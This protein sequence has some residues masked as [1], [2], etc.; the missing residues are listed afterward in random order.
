[1]GK[2]QS[3]LEGLCGHALSYGAESIEVLRESDGRWWV[4][5]NQ[6]GERLSIF[7]CAASSSDWTELRENLE[8][9]LKKPVRTVF[10]G[11]V[12]LLKATIPGDDAFRVSTEMAPKIDP[13]APPK[14]TSRQGQYLAYIHS[15]TKVHRYPP[16]ESDLQWHFGVS[17]PAIHEMI[18]TLERNGLIEKVPGQARSIRVCVDPKRLPSLE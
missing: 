2:T 8:A 16:A 9:A 13:S 15:Y 11:K 4:Y 7:K 1:M 12:F 6:P 10:G 5:M 18:K 17:A 3:L 14:F